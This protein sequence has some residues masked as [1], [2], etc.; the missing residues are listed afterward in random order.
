VASRAHTNLSVAWSSLGDL[1]RAREAL[2]EGLARAEKEGDAQGSWFMRGNLLG[3]RFSSGDWDGALALAQSFA[4]SPESGYQ[5]TG[6]HDILARILLAR[7]D[8]AAAQ[9]EMRLA[10]EQAQ[11]GDAQMWWPTLISL[12]HFARRSGSLEECRNAIDEVVE[13]LADSET[14]GDPQEWHVELVLELDALDRGA[15]AAKMVA[16]LPEGLWSRVCGAAVERA[17]AEAADLLAS[18]GE[19]P[20]QARLRLLAARQLAAEG[21]LGDAE[22]QLNLARA[23]W[24]SVDAV[25]Y[26]READE[27]LAA[28]S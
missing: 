7:G 8:E 25:A 15:D 18:M 12:A 28:A 1:R 17:Y 26:L 5:E 6:A 21:R 13:A 22:Q 2:E 11:G 16:R 4:A 24:A 10:V 9:T 27:V 20:L 19:E 14:V 23:F 3:S